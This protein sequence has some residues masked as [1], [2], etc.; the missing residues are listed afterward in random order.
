MFRNANR[1]LL[2]AI[3]I[4]ISSKMNRRVV[5]RC[6]FVSVRRREFTDLLALRAIF[7]LDPLSQDVMVYIGS[8]SGARRGVYIIVTF[9]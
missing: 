2:S 6:L 4:D 7:S 5:K 8:I 3:V 1:R 9:G